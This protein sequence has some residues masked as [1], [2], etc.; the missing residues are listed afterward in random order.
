MALQ[1]GQ[2]RFTGESQC[3]NK[4]STSLSYRKS[5]SFQNVLVTPTGSD[6]VKGQDYYFSISIPQDLNYDL[7]FDV[8][9][10]RSTTAANNSIYQYLKSVSIEKGGNGT[11]VYSACLYELS[12]GTVSCM[13]PA[14]YDSSKSGEV[15]KIYRQSVS[16]EEGYRYYLWDG[17][18][19]SRTTKVNAVEIPA[20][21]NIDSTDNYGVFEMVF[22][23]VEDG[24][25][26]ILLD[27][28]RTA[29]DY[30]IQSLDSQGNVVFGRNVDIS[31]V[32]NTKL[33]NLKNLVS[34]VHN[35]GSL[36]RI[37]V[38]GHPG[39]TLAIDGEEIHV[40]ASGYYEEDVLPISSLGIV[41]NDYL[42]NWTL[43]YSY[44]TEE[45]VEG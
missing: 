28:K 3:V 42:D 2:L 12:N 24:F 44:D 20:S 34:S 32:T 45:E 13:I 26:S 19:Y 31:K 21:W 14:D 37:G 41:A 17:T 30:S 10:V 15:G 33:Y 8:K 29:I 4:L 40:G 18:A 36:T 1:I 9:L 7:E 35:G 43:D 16:G 11:N 22:R 38:W 23:P 39:L 25:S 6:F 5:G 27:M